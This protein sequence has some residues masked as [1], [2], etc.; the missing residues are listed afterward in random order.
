MAGMSNSALAWNPT[1]RGIR[2]HELFSRIDAKDRIVEMQIPP[3]RG[4]GGLT[5]LET[6]VLLTASRIV[7]AKRVFE[8]GTFRGSTTLNLALNIPADGRVFTLD[9][10]PQCIAE[11]SQHPAD[12]QFTKLHLAT[13]ALDFVGS[14]VEQKIQSLM[15]NS[16]AFDFS[17]WK[18]SIDLV[19]IDGGHDYN[20]VK[21]DTENVLVQPEMEKRRSPLV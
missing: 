11:V 21:S 17:E 3:H 7:K 10:D 20:T 9:L 8:F 12:T 14:T 5:L 6:C 2:P 15:G 16:V 1:V 4:A 13:P 18:D 19:F